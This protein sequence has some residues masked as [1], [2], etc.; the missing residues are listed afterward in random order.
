[1]FPSINLSLPEVLA[2]LP[3]MTR[4]LY[5][6]SS[7]ALANPT[8]VD[9]TCGI[10]E[11]GQGQVGVCSG[12]LSQLSVGSTVWAAVQDH[13]SSFRLPASPETPLLLIGPGTGLA[14]LYGFLG[15]LRALK[16]EGTTIG[17]VFLFFGCRNQKEYIY[18]E[19][20][21]AFVDDG[22]LTE[23]YIAFSREG[24]RQYVQHLMPAVADDLWEKVFN[25]NGHVFV[26]GDASKMAPDVKNALKNVVQLA[27][28]TT[29]SEASIYI[30]TMCT[31]DHKRYHQDVWASSS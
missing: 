15:E 10:T 14:P 4:R 3:Q 31:G 9:I 27:S 8:S 26:C 22:T 17:Q 16:Q 25:A 30:D 21:K 24:K 28:N 1:M 29:A 5:S 6:I 12:Y 23:L 11:F 2:V 20:L 19:D 13:G 7:S 18:E